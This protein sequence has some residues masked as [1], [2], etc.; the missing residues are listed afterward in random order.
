[1]KSNKLLTIGLVVAGLMLPSLGN[2]QPEALTQ[3][4]ETCFQSPYIITGRPFKSI[5]TGDEVAEF[6][7][8]LFEGTTYRIA[9]G[10]MGD[11]NIIFSVYD[12]Q[13]H[14]LFTNAD[15]Q[16]APYWDFQA[17]GYIDCLVEARLDNKKT[18]SGFAI[19]MTGFKLNEED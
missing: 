19:L 1:M 15:K 6:N 10:S 7:L 5:L 14:L 4:C 11:P 16:N 8:T 2:S 18:E 12:N 17:T 3:S 9:A 13:R